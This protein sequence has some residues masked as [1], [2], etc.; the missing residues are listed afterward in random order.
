MKGQVQDHPG[1]VVVPVAADTTTRTVVH[2]L[3][4]PLLALSATN[5]ACLSGGML[6]GIYFSKLAVSLL[7]FTCELSEEPAG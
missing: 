4:S 1:S 5:V 2:P 7:R 6:A 3:V